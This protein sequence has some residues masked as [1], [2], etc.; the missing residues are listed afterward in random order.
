MN[1]YIV[2]CV[3]S[4]YQQKLVKPILL[5]I[6]SYY[7]KTNNLINGNIISHNS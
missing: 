7:L 6:F 1:K 3:F 4:D 5:S 2:M